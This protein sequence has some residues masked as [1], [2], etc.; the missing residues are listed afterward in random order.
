MI[1]WKA[2]FRNKVWLASFIAFIVGTVFSFLAMFD[3]H[4][5]ISE[6]FILE[7]ADKVLTLLGLIGIIVDPTTEGIKDSERAMTYY[8]E[9]D[10]RLTE[11]K[12]E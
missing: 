9:E 5:S 7:I 12:G 1:N 8:T 2:R 4:P 3:V 6:N 11:N 10:V